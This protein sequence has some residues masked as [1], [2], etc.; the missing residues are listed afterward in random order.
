MTEKYTYN[1]YGIFPKPIYQT[2]IKEPLN[3]KQK[4]Y[5]KKLK[6][7]PN[8]GNDITSESF[9]LD[10][11][12]FKNFKQKIL[13][14][15]EDYLFNVLKYEK[16]FTPYIT[17]SWLNYTSKNQHHHNHQHPNSFIS[18]VYYIDVDEKIDKIIFSKPEYE[19]I[20]PTLVEFNP[21]NSRDW[22]FNVK[23]QDLFIFSSNMLHRVDIKKDSHIRI[24]LAFNVFIRGKVGNLDDKTWLEI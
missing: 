23:N 14:H 5:L 12:L 10:N 18:G 24:S 13:R 22:F 8:V 20:K 17:Q 15:V 7:R 6:S 3:K 11:K 2:N 19:L 9:V 4:D 16:T 21:L 1:V